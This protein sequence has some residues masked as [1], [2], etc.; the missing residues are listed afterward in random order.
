MSDLPADPFPVDSLDDV[1]L[2]DPAR[3][4][5][6]QAAMTIAA[7]HGDVHGM[8]TLLTE[9]PLVQRGPALFSL[10]VIL[11]E[12]WRA[13]CERSGVDA[14]ADAA[15]TLRRIALLEGGDRA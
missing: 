6:I 13:A 7:L 1:P 5:R 2:T 3:V 4:M 9:L 15:E 11:A 14:D 8:T 12:K 10:I